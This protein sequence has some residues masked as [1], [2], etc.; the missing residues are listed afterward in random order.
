M[1]REK[2]RRINFALVVLG[3]FF[4]EGFIKIASSI[5]AALVMVVLLPIIYI[6]IFLD[7]IRGEKN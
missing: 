7:W 5:I 1:N 2:T 4:V 6:Q 3:L